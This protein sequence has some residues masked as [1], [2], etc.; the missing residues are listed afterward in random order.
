[1]LAPSDF[2]FSNKWICKVGYHGDDT[3]KNISRWS[4]A[5]AKLKV[6]GEPVK[7]TDLLE[8]TDADIKENQYE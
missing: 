3:C 8:R 6:E 1:M 2:S 4:L 7:Y 5:N